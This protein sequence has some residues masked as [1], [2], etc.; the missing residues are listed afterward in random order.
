MGGYERTDGRIILP[1]KV[2]KPPCGCNI[3]KINQIQP[4]SYNDKSSVF[5]GIFKNDF[6][7]SILGLIFVLGSQTRW[8][9][10]L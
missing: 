1:V 7:D 10:Y 5:Y 9:I 4:L 2:L 8:P 6:Y 3:Y